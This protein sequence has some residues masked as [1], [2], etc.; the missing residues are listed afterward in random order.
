MQLPLQHM[1][2]DCS[3]LF[4][5]NEV[6]HITCSLGGLAARCGDAHASSGTLHNT[7]TPIQDY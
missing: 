1:Q 4:N 6:H 2:S 7:E 5:E 3:T